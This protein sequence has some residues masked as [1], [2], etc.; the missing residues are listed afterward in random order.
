MQA[1]DL[2]F[3]LPFRHRPIKASYIDPEVS[4]DKGVWSQQESRQ[5]CSIEFHVQDLVFYCTLPPSLVHL[6]KRN[7]KG[8]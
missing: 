5:G 4:P 1:L 8:N 7:T 3:L 6:Q 2:Y